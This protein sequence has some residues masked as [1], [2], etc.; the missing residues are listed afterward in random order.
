LVI[1]ACMML[2]CQI[3]RIWFVIAMT[4]DDGGT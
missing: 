2:S 1:R 4:S 3:G